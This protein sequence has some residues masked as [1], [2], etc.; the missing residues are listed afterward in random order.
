MKRLILVLFIAFILFSCDDYAMENRKLLIGTWED[1]W[2][3]D[4]RD[5][6]KVR[7]IF[8]ENEFT[9][10]YEGFKDTIEPEWPH[11]IIGK[12][13]TNRIDKGTYTADNSTITFIFNTIDDK[14]VTDV[15]AMVNYSISNNELTLIIR[16]E[17][18][19]YK[20]IN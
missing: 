10:A 20:K 17:P 5:I 18:C 9:Y 1:T 19:V 8:S 15:S 6:Y 12:E 2:E 13:P 4:D 11:N 14:N 3:D 7:Y 16:D